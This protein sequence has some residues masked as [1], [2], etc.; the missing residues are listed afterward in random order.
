MDLKT[1][2]ISGCSSGLGEALCQHFLNQNWKVIA[3]TRTIE[4]ELFTHPNFQQLTYDPT[5]ADFKKIQALLAPHLQNGLD[6]LINNAGYA[7]VGALESLDET[8][9]RKQMEVN[10]FSH[11]M[12]TKS[13]IQALRVKSGKI[14]NLSSLFGMIGCPFHTLYCAS[15]FAIEG[16]SEALH[17]ELYPQGIQCSVIEPGRYKTHF[18]K[19]MNMMAPN[20]K[21]QSIYQD[22]YQGFLKLKSDLSLKKANDTKRFAEKLFML[23]NCRK[24][25]LR[26]P[27]DLDSKIP[28]VLKRILPSRLFSSM[29]YKFFAKY[30]RYHHV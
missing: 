18:G 25:P 27:I 11:V 10:F 17:Y 4:R 29:Q 22:A 23:A 26:V 16:F 12:V 14:F 5:Q 8:A 1:V 19:H 9:M 7:L 24:V 30:F 28:Y 2:V 15:K 21:D 3:L 6:L 20:D 13:C